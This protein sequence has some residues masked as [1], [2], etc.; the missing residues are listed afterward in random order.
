MGKKSSIL[1]RFRKIMIKTAWLNPLVINPIKKAKYVIAR[2]ADTAKVIPNKYSSKVKVCLETAIDLG[3]IESKTYG[4]KNTTNNSNNTC[5]KIKLVYTGRFVDSKGLDIIFR[6]IA[7]SKYKENLELILIGSGGKIEYYKALSKQLGIEKLVTFSGKM[8]RFEL[9]EQLKQC[10]IYLCSSFREGGS[11]SLMEGMGAGL[12][13][14]CID[15]SG[16]HVITNDDCAIRIP[17]SSID[18]TVTRFSKA[19]DKLICDDKLR[20]KM[21]LEARKR[22]EQEFNWDSKGLFLEAILFN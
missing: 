16:M 5:E 12:P 1:Q 8:K 10:D 17:V 22:I 11:W 21:G 9:L 4:V 3:E 18:E 6:A 20:E 13:V 7:E 15:T 14:I 19:I 2:T